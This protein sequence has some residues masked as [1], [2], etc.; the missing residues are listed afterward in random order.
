MQ[1][2]IYGAFAAGF[3]VAAAFFLRFWGRTRAPLLMIFALAF[4]LMAM[5]YVFLGTLQIP[6][7]EQGWIYLVR[8]ASFTLIIIGIIWTNL[9][10]RKQ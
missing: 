1:D 7:E 8:L 2:F 10:G 3:L 5:T 9:R 4:A 6:R